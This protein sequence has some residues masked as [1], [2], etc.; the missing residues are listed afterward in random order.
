MFDRLSIPNWETLLLKQKTKSKHKLC[1]WCSYQLLFNEDGSTEWPSL[2]QEGHSI[3]CTILRG[4]LFLHMVRLWTVEVCL[5]VCIFQ[6]QTTAT[7]IFAVH[8]QISM[9][10]LQHVFSLKGHAADDTIL[11]MSSIHYYFRKKKPQCATCKEK[12][13]FCACSCILN[14]SERAKKREFD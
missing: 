10:H 2:D 13:F 8:L 12:V 7:Y 14:Y 1:A 4:H 5:F 9:L 11:N 6:T 3:L